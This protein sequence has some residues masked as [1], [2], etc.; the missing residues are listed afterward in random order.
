MTQ[1]TSLTPSM[2]ALAIILGVG[3][4]IAEATHPVPNQT[5]P[6]LPERMTE[7]MVK[8]ILMKIEGDQVVIKVNAGQAIKLHVDGN[9]KM[10]EVVVGDKVKAYVNDSGYVTT[11]QRHE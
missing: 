9:T 1:L 6:T 7:E 3:S 11:L 10:G 2:M 4:G 5:I 8:G